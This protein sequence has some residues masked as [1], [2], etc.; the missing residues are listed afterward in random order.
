[1]YFYFGTNCTDDTVLVCCWENQG[2]LIFP[3]LN[4]AWGA[5]KEVFKSR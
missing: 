4:A 5:A 3:T 2:I 1:M